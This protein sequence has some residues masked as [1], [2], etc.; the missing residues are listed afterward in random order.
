MHKSGQ[1]EFSIREEKIKNDLSEIEEQ[2]LLKQRYYQM[3][4]EE[5]KKR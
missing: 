3:M 2:E 5:E 1:L 4:E